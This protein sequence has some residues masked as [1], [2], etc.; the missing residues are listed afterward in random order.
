MVR[1]QG[2]SILGDRQNTGQIMLIFT[3]VEIKL[4]REED[5]DSGSS[6]QLETTK[7]SFLEMDMDANHRLLGLGD[8][9]FTPSRMGRSVIECIEEGSSNHAGCTLVLNQTAN[10][11]NDIQTNSIEIKDVSITIRRAYY[12]GI[13]QLGVSLSN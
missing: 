2:R 6:Y 13:Y 12:E 11:E 10:G 9:N 3:F 4:S 1:N 5:S 8:Y 7:P